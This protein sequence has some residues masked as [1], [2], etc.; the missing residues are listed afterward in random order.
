M[1][2]AL[3][4]AP[5]TSAGP[6]RVVANSGHE[7]PTIDAIC[8]DIDD[9]LIDFTGSARSALSVVIGSVPIDRVPVGGDDLWP[10]WQRV[11]EEHSALCVA[12]ALD[13]DAM[14]HARTKAFLADLGRDLDDDTVAALEDRRLAQMSRAW[15]PFPDVVPCLDWLRAAGLRLAAVTNASGPRQRERLASLGLARFFDAVVSAGELGTAKPDPVIF[16]TACDRLGVTPATTAHIGDRLDHDA[17]GARDAGLHGI[18]LD[19]ANTPAP[20]TPGIPVIDTLA[21]LPALLVTEY[22]TPTVTSTSTLPV[23]RR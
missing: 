9:T 1:T 18:W 3:V 5:S 8:L 17:Q 22:R 19:R 15:R 11:T 10:A 6:G 16:H 7:P 4:P 12:G 14:R 23:P 20:P 21:D 2:S 13:Y